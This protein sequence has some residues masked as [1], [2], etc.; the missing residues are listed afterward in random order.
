MVENSTM[1]MP[2]LEKSLV[3]CNFFCPVQVLNS[4]EEQCFSR[5]TALIK[6]TVSGGIVKLGIWHSLLTERPHGYTQRPPM[7]QSESSLTAD[8]GGRNGKNRMG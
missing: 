4:A 7:D 2:L 3:Q 1:D 5:G 6:I 8:L